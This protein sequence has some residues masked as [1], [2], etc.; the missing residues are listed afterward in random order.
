MSY[1]DEVYRNL[2]MDVFYNG[3]WDYDEDVRAKYKDG[4]NAY[5][6]SLFGYQVKFPKGIL[7]LITTKKVFTQTAIKEM[8][9]FWVKQTVKKSDFDSWNVKIWDDWMNIYG[10]LGE[11]YAAQ[12]EKRGKSLI[13]V[14]NVRYTGEVAT[15]DDFAN[16]DKQSSRKE[17]IL[18]NVWNGMLNRCCNEKSDK[19]QDYG[20]RGIL[21][22][23]DW[24]SYDNFLI[25][26]VNVPHYFSAK[27][28]N[29]IGWELDKDYFNS[30][31]Y[32]KETCVWLRVRENKTYTRN[33]N[34]LLI[35]FKNGEKEKHLSQASIC[36]KYNLSSSSLCRDIQSKDF[37]SK[38]YSSLDIL[39]IEK[40][41]ENLRRELGR[42]QVVELIKGLKENPKSRRHMT[43][44]WD[45]ENSQNKAL[46]ECAWA[47]QWDVRKGELNLL[48]IQRSVDIALGLPFNWFQYY[49]LQCLVAHVC[50]YEV[51]T[52]TH[53]MGNVHYYNRHSKDLLEQVTSDYYENEPKLTINSDLKDFFKTE[54]SDIKLDSYKCS[55]RNIKY[56]IAV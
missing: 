3:D 15:D 46:Q 34:P 40:L 35:T 11:S 49:V 14:P 51:G 29:F 10:D 43:S 21:V 41:D 24:V 33:V 9:L 37:S 56:D 22:A 53:Q 17:E 55:N 25:D 36:E 38:R 31:V 32:S 47:T 27:K 52:F 44:F 48:L 26:V 6:K 8:L 13:E 50:G 42:N 7:P 1:A 20:S 30:N 4:E 39:T 12:F 2:V 28:E 54:L 45:F 5:A 19:Y 16:R 18:Y 23:K